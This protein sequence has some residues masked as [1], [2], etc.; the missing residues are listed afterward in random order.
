MYRSKSWDSNES[1]N[2]DEN[3]NKDVITT[4]NRKKLWKKNLSICVKEK[5]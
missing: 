4:F 1:D 2:N 3:A 5:L